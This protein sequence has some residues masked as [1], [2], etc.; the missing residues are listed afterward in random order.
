MPDNTAMTELITEDRGYLSKSMSDSSQFI[1]MPN[2]NDV[3]RPL[4]DVDDMVKQMLTIYNDYDA[5]MKKA[6]TAYD[7]VHTK[8]DWQGTIG[9]KWVSLFNEAKQALKAPE[10]EVISDGG[11]ENIIEAE[12]F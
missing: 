3:I 11:E 7:W 5:A 4:V 10:V 1:I 2:D 12:S 6:D 8:M 9:K